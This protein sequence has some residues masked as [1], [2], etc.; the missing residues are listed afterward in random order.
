VDDDDIEFALICS[1]EKA[2]SFSTFIITLSLATILKASPAQIGIHIHTVTPVCK[3]DE[4]FLRAER[5]DWMD[6]FTV[7]S[8]F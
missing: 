8:K 4:F 7:L 2:S 6:D 5:S 1:S 3:N